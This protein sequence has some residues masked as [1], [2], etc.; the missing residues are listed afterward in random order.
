MKRWVGVVLFFVGLGIGFS[1][2]GSD[3]TPTAIP[4]AR[5]VEIEVAPQECIDALDTAQRG[6][7]LAAE[8]MDA[9][10]EGFFAVANGDLAGLEAAGAKAERVVG[11]MEALDAETFQANVQVCRA[12]AA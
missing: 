5:T 1:L 2:G 9:S 8:A 4:E 6:F 11:R 7:D 10:S 3:P 12:A